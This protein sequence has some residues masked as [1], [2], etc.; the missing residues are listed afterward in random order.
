MLYLAQVWTLVMALLWLASFVEMLL[1]RG[2]GR[3]IQNVFVWSWVVLVVIIIA[4]TYKSVWAWLKRHAVV[5]F[6][7]VCWTAVCGCMYYAHT[8]AVADVERQHQVELENIR[9]DMFVNQEV[10]R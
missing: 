6:Q 4:G 2:H 8:V 7:L 5:L 9:H 10:S 3:S 1:T